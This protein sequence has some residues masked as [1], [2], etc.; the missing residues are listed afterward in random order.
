MAG[1]DAPLA[2][3]RRQ[4]VDARRLPH[5]RR[6]PDGAGRPRLRERALPRL[7]RLH[8][9]GR[10]AVSG[11]L[12]R[13]LR[14]VRSAGR[15]VGAR[16]GHGL[17]PARAARSHGLHRLGAQRADPRLGIRAQRRRA[18]VGQ[19]RPAGR[20]QPAGRREPAGLH[21]LCGWRR[22]LR[23]RVA[24]PGREQPG[25][26][27]AHRCSTARKTPRAST[28]RPADAWRASVH[29]GRWTS[30]TGTTPTASPTPS[31]RRSST[32]AVRGTWSR[33]GA[34]APPAAR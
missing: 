4:R 6:R 30:P 5:F 8:E 18:L 25:E 26:R 32:R 24:S 23:A 19:V 31:S 21:A 20:A 11:R 7:V 13:R 3:Q 1:G 22:A 27:V 34:F 15:A 29:R 17:V 16:R 28:T 33:P 10:L 2:G 14:A 12:S 9:A